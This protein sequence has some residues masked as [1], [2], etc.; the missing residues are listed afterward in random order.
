M[1]KI[2]TGFLLL[3]MITTVAQPTEKSYG[4]PSVAT[5]VSKIPA[6]VSK[7]VSVSLQEGGTIP[8]EAKFTCDNQ[9][10]ESFK[11]TAGYSLTHFFDG[12]KDILNQTLQAYKSIGGIAKEVKSDYD[13]L[14]EQEVP[15]FISKSELTIQGSNIVYYTLKTGCIQDKNETS[16]RVYYFV[17]ISDDSNFGTIQ[18][19]LYD[20]TADKAGRY[21]AEI[22]Q[23]LKAID[24]GSIQ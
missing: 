11:S 13:H 5:D 2:F 6:A 8:S 17:R 15:G 16:T 14:N 1:K 18:I 4:L 9:V 23:K 12:G 7:G 10:A 19:V 24:Y 22:L 20:G 21:A 3:A